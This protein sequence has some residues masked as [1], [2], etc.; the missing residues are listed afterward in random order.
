MESL[1]LATARIRRQ[2]VTAKGPKAK[3][4]L[5]PEAR[6]DAGGTV[7]MEAA[8]AGARPKAEW[9]AGS[10]NPESGHP[11]PSSAQCTRQPNL[12]CRD[13]CRRGSRSHRIFLSL[14][15]STDIEFQLPTAGPALLQT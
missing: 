1:I 10:E 11:G 15:F 12:T 13:Q 4:K 14:F 3:H 9:P 8:P 5:R 2:S 7:Q 6:R